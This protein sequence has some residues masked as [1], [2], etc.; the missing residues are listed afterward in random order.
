[1]AGSDL[2]LCEEARVF[3]SSPGTEVLPGK[4]GGTQES[5]SQSLQ[6]CC[7]MRAAFPSLAGCLLRQQTD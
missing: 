6:G 3:L 5:G 1:M 4:G 2:W 7:K